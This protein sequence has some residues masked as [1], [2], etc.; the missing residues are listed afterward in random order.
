MSMVE[1]IGNGNIREA[2]HH[3][4]MQGRV[5]HAQMFVAPEGAGALAV[6]IEYASSVLGI[7]R[8]HIFS[9]PDLHLAYPVNTTKDVK[10]DPVSDDFAPQWR[11][12]VAENV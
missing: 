1:V 8:E 4:M 12:F 10:K 2:L 3:S 9:C 6:A 11:R 7:D 5:S